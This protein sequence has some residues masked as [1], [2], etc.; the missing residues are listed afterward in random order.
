MAGATDDALPYLERALRL[1][2]STYGQ[3]HPHTAAAL[4]NLASALSEHGEH[5]E[6]IENWAQSLEIVRASYGN[7]HW[8]TARNLGNLAQELAEKGD[9]E[10][11]R[12]LYE[13]SY[14]IRIQLFGSDHPEVGVVLA[15]L[16]DL[17]T[18]VN[19]PAGA[20]RHFERAER[21]IRA[22][23]GITHPTL[24]FAMRGIAAHVARSD[25]ARAVRLLRES[26]WIV[27]EQYGTDH[28]QTAEALVQLA[29]QL[30]ED[31]PDEAL[32]L[33]EQAL[34]IHLRSGRPA[35]GQAVLAYLIGSMR[36]R[37]DDPAG[38]RQAFEE[39]VRIDT[40]VFGAGHAE[41]LIDKTAM[42][43]T[44]QKQGDSREARACLTAAID[45][46]DAADAAAPSRKH[47]SAVLQ[48]YDALAEILA[49]DDAAAARAAL[50]KAVALAEQPGER[51]QRLLRLA[52]LCA[53]TGD[54]R[55]ANTARAR[56]VALLAE[57]PTIRLA[58]E[59][60]AELRDDQRHKWWTPR[61]ARKSAVT[62][63][64]R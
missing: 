61:G 13:E 48:A 6:A 36:L 58:L 52:D 50:E 53:A 7:L 57:D 17:Q 64:A 45:A 39:A 40:E 37:H 25:P 3:Q 30:A 34:D 29:D 59:T 35:A 28:P 1:F 32:G 23:A 56:L 42:A 51:A 8:W 24:P 54:R 19:D 4:N 14:E 16:A 26:L 27:E 11:A 43:R 33:R 55:A 15:Q 41:V 5:D 60:Y 38:A 47:A 62:G 18:R 31:E 12:A 20:L 49:E 46:T 9:L 22:G 44:W 2:Q 63:A 21:I 10:A